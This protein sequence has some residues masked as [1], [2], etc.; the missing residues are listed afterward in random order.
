MRLSRFLAL[1]ALTG[2]LSFPAFA[3]DPPPGPEAAD[4]PEEAQGDEIIVIAGS[5]LGRVDAPQAPIDTLDEA[6]IAAYGAG[7]LAEL[8]EALA[9][10]TG[11]GRGRG[12]GMPVFLVNGLRVSSFREMRSYPPEAVQRVEI[13]PEEVAQRF[14][15]S[16]NQRVVNFI[17]KDN[18]SS[19]EIEVEYGQPDR[20]GFSRKEVEAT[21]LRIDGSSRLNANVEWND[22]SPLTE[23]ERGVIQSSPPALAG[24]PD[25]AEYRTLIGDSA[26]L[27]TTLNWST[28][29]GDVSSLSLNGTFERERSLSLQGLDTVLLTDPDGESLFRTF[30]AGDPLGVRTKTETYALGSTFNTMFGEWDFT[31]TLDGRHVVTNSEIDRRADTAALVLAAANGTLAPDAPIDLADAG[32]E[33]ARTQ[34]DSFNSLA[35]LSGRPVELPAGEV[36]VTFDAGYGWNRIESVDT[37]NAG[38]ETALKRG[39]LS[40][41]VNVGVPIASRD[42]DHWA[43]LGNVDLNLAAGVN[44]LSDFGT[45]KDWSLGLNWGITERLGVSVTYIGADAAPGLSQLGDPEIATPNVP[46]FDLAR[47]ETVLATVI[48]GGN[49]LLPAQSQRDWKVS[50]VWDLP[51]LDRSTLSVDYSRNSSYDI[52]SGFPVL[53][54]Q[55]EAIFPDRIERN[56]DGSLVSVDRRPVTFHSQKSQRI[57]TGL[58]LSGPFGKARPE[59]GESEGA[60]QGRG[61]F[62]GRSAGG[63]GA[64]P[65]GPG[66][67]GG[68]GGGQFDFAAL[69]ERMCAKDPA[70]GE[71]RPLTQEELDQ[72]PPF[73]RE[74]LQGEDGQI[75]MARLTEMR[76][77]F[78]SAEGQP[79]GQGAPGGQMPFDPERFALLREQFCTPDPITGQQREIS[80]AD[81]AELPEPM[82]ARLRDENGEID[83]ERL[84]QL[85]E[86]FCSFDPN[87]PDAQGQQGQQ[88]QQGGGARRGGRGGGGFGPG[89]GGDGR[90]RW[91]FN[92]THTYEFE[93]EVLVAPGGPLLDLLDGDALGGAS[94]RHSARLT[95]GIFYRGFG[96]RFSG[97]YT[98]NARIDG[99]GL[100]GSTDLFFND[101]V[102]FDVRIFAD[103][104]QQEKLVE[105]APF[106]KNTRVSF[107]IDNILDARQRVTDAD[108][109]VP[110]RYQ[111]FLQDP[112][113]R[114]LGV[115]LRKMF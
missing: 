89:G 17:L 92:L 34:V 55:I 6:D 57:Q 100:P 7:S 40:A 93:N 20:G 60:V 58:N 108:G 112:T 12:G 4:V 18:Y 32:F 103:L 109:V 68:F 72:I 94:P 51:I 70:T 28:K 21:Y 106:L 38:I 95:G 101:Y 59:P 5:L 49:P 23:A 30:I 37:R 90:G 75:D 73:M 78:C 74:R 24:D 86:R 96:T 88:A 104:N 13:L 19:R 42:Y 25:P 66:A 43:A 115:E 99:S 65:A 102:T 39:D 97:N 76:Q 110:L 31:G 107:R 8:V 61:G 77:R 46:I 36:S 1:T 62:G 35:T 87:N 11:S 56:A 85:R 79:F 111:P 26:G 84:A 52:T 41:G 54:P 9:P 67:A 15:F 22:T 81:L 50:L 83:P 2:T 53:T 27:E 113:G 80:E 105:S 3:Q 45:L 10:Q 29:L 69:R 47:N 14:G 44:H 71:L 16:P 64:G 98:G 114:Y 91:F 82:L 48:S 63:Q 33:S